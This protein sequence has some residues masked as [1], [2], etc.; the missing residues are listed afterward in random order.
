MS[1]MG[2]LATYDN[3][4]FLKLTL[5]FATSCFRTDRNLT[6]VIT[7]THSSYIDTKVFVC[8]C[9]RAGGG[10]RIYLVYTQ[11]S[12]KRRKRRFKH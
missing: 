6:L 5:A 2:S 3:L 10:E 9:V 11:L 1:R 8:V 7:S 12:A 4:Y